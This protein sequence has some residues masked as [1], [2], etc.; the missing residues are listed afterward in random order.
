VRGEYGEGEARPQGGGGLECRGREEA[1]TEVEREG[2]SG[3]KDKRR[4]EERT[5]T[6][7][8]QGERDTEIGGG[9]VVSHGRP[10]ENG[11]GRP[12]VGPVDTRSPCLL[13][14]RNGKRRRDANALELRAM[15]TRYK[16]S[17]RASGATGCTHASRRGCEKME[18]KC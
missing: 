11:P 13:V 7:A 15:V 17:S 1:E 10:A 18:E 6:Q 2:G 12:G 16:L 14:K 3:F 4:E 8:R 9:V 5:V